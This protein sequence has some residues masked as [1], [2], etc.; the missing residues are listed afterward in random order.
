MDGA[1]LNGIVLYERSLPSESRKGFNVGALAVLLSVLIL[2]LC[3]PTTVVNKTRTVVNGT[4]TVLTHRRV[5]LWRGGDA[6]GSVSDA[7]Q[8]SGKLSALP[9]PAPPM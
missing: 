6:V 2:P 8:S 7:R 1:L 3:Q 5:T 9:V 4:R